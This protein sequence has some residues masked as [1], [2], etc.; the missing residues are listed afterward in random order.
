MGAADKRFVRAADDRWVA[1]VCGGLAGFLG[2]SAG[3]VRACYAVLTVIGAV[4][5]G[6]LVYLILWAALPALPRE[7][8]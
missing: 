5:P 6:V 1:G 4:V 3:V 2:V 7:E 8:S